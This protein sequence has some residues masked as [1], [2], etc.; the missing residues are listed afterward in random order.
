MAA[1]PGMGFG[2]TH[3]RTGGIRSPASKVAVGGGSSTA[4][5]AQDGLSEVSA[6][7]ELIPGGAQITYRATTDAPTVNVNE[8]SRSVAPT[9]TS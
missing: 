7:Y 4:P 3:R 8:I 1:V 9:G 6:R 2:A 5:V